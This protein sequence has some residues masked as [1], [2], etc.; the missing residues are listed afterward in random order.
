MK[1][2][3]RW[4]GA[5]IGLVVLLFVVAI[6]IGTSLPIAHVATCSAQ[7]K[8]SPATLRAA[9][10]DDATSTSWRSDVK[11]VHR[12]ATSNGETRWVE[13]YNSGQTLPYL[14]RL[15]SWGI[16]RRIDD[17][18]LPFADEWKY[19]FQSSGGGT[20]MTISEFGEIYNPV[21]RLIEH[22]FTGYSATIKTYMTDLGK[23]YDESPSI[24]CSVTTYPGGLPK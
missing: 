12:E 9:V 8:Q 7:Y 22:F 17:P 18:D 20:Q 4:I 10:A 21:F 3:I 19:K 15:N 14:E 1:T 24:A 2:V 13:T 5:V 11:A 16:D 6:A 23:K